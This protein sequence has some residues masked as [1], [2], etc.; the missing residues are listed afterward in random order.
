MSYGLGEHTEVIKGRWRLID[1][2]IIDSEEVA[3]D[4]SIDNYGAASDEEGDIGQEEAG[5]NTG[6]TESGTKRWK[7]C[8]RL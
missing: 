4:D 5:V 8:S 6:V 1:M 7:R 3:E 2:D